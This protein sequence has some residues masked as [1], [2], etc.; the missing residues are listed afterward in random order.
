MIRRAAITA[1]AIAVL[2][3][4]GCGGSTPKA[5]RGATVDPTASQG[6]ALSGIPAVKKIGQPHTL[7]GGATATLIRLKVSKVTAS[8]LGDPASWKVVLATFRLT[9]PAGGKPL[10]P[11]GAQLA[12]TAGPDGIEANYYN[13]QGAG[14]VTGTSAFGETPIRPGAARTATW[15]VATPSTKQIQMTVTDQTGASWSWLGDAA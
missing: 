11:T 3:L 9:N 4:A 14:G 12:I 5:G 6:E 8:S 1:A 13:Y 7:E 10:D 15:Q 2:A